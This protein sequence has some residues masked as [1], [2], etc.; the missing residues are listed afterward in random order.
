MKK[1][2]F[3]PEFWQQYLAQPD[4]VDYPVIFIHGIARRE[5]AWQKTAQVITDSCYCQMRYEAESNIFHNYDGREAAA[6]VWSLT[7]YTGQPLVEAVTGNLD[8]Y[9]AR[10]EAMIE[11]IKRITGQEKVVL[12]AHSM[13][14]LVARKYMVKDRSNWEIVHKILTV[15]TPNLG[16]KVAVG[17]VGQLKDVKWGSEFITE[18]NQNWEALS[19][20]KNKKWGVIGAVNPGIV[21]GVEP[22]G[23]DSCGPGYVK[24]KSA[25]PYETEAAVENFGQVATVTGHFGFRLAVEADHVELLFHEGTLRGIDWA[26][27]K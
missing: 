1:D 14:G 6:R 11:I 13:G 23:T 9:A 18:L 2:Y 24:L 19:S 21:R 5:E 4:T 17:I 7:Y 16:V 12:V 27:K 25:I 8:L 3:S 22:K 15:G 10:L 20:Y 26:V